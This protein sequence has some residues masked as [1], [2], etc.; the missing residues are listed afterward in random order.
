[1][2]VAVRWRTCRCPVWLQFS[3]SL[4]GLGLHVCLTMYLLCCAPSVSNQWLSFATL[5]W[6]LTL[7]FR[8][9]FMCHKQ[10][11][12]S[13]VCIACG[14]VIRLVVTSLGTACASLCLVEAGLLQCRPC[15]PSG[16]N[17]GADPE[18]A[19]CCSSFGAESPATW[20]YLGGFEGAAL[21]SQSHSKST[22]SCACLSTSHCVFRCRSISATCWSLLL[23]TRHWQRCARQQTG[24]TL[25]LA[26]TF[27]TVTEHFLSLFPKPGTVYPLGNVVYMHVLFSIQCVLTYSELIGVKTNYGKLILATGKIHFVSSCVFP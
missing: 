8:C 15:R 26:P 18:S 2:W 7:S 14:F 13:T 5:K 16:F 23:T 10:C 25:S 3:L 20:S 27:G 9:T 6:W 4:P 12:H 19:A 22:T 21:A 1:M 11:R 17:V 24:T